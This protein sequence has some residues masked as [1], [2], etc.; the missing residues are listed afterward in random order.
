MFLILILIF[1]VHRNV[2]EKEL[3]KI[4]TGKTT[5]RT[6]KTEIQYIPY[7]HIL[8]DLVMWGVM[9]SSTVTIMALFFMMQFGPQYLHKVLLDDFLLIR[10]L[11]CCKWAEFH[12][13]S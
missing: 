11:Y 4:E 6:A 3:T 10:R 8:T 13:L 1:S 9:F 2:S 7:R 5:V 12:C